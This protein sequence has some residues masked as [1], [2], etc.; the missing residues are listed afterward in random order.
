MSY[1]TN[2][3][4]H[5]ILLP[6]NQK[7]TNRQRNR[8]NAAEQR[9]KQKQS[10]AADTDEIQALRAQ[11]GRMEGE[12]AGYKRKLSDYQEA[13][14]GRAGER[15]RAAGTGT[16]TGG[17]ETSLTVSLG[18][19]GSAPVPAPAPVTPDSLL[20]TPVQAAVIAAAATIATTAIAT[21]A[22]AIATTAIATVVPVAVP[23]VVSLS[24]CAA[25]EAA[26]V[27]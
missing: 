5:K 6:I 11:V 9:R 14:A 20:G 17:G 13:A 24:D 3:P 18:E 26:A 1:V 19:E 23:S 21:A 27:A 22:T 4:Y 7:R 25:E 12:I 15:K 8:R 10:I 16:G 2:I